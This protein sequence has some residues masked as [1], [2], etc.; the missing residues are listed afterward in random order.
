MKNS[1]YI[2]A[3]QQWIDSIVI[4]EN[5]CPFAKKEIKQHSVYFK[6]SQATTEETLLLDLGSE[7]ER[8]INTPSIETSFI[9]H[10]FTLTLFSDYV[11]FIEIADELLSALKLDGVFQIAH[12][13]P[14]YC[15][16]HSSPNDA[17]NYSNRSP[18][19]MLH[20]LRE[21]SIEQAVKLFPNPKEIPSNNIKKLNHLG[22]SECKARLANCL[23]I[24]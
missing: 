1:H 5:L 21:E 7:L 12:F 16:A 23:K 2:K 18:Y 17:A 14:D 4:A 3:T 19:P 9:I 15:F 13:H 6:C 8:L 24:H 22:L 20:L 11:S 10:P